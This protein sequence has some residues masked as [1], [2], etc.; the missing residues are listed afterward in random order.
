VTPGVQAE[1]RATLREAGLRGSFLVRDL[2]SGDSLAVDPDVVLPLASLAK[3]PL[4]VTIAERI[5]SGELDPAM[6]IDVP[7][8]HIGTAGPVGIARFRH[9]ARV[10]LED[11]LY[12]AVSVSDNAAADELFALAAPAE[13]MATLDTAGIG[14]IT[15]R[16]DMRPLMETPVERMPAGEAHLA[17]ALAIGAGT[18]DGAHLVTQLDVSRTNTGTAAACADVLDELWNPRA[19]S[20]AAATRVRELMRHNVFRQRLAPDF[21]SDAMTW[22]SKTATLL[23]LRHEAGV[24]EHADGQ[25]IAVVALSESL[26]PAAVQPG[27]EAQISL[28]ARRLHDELRAR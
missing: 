2:D 20:P 12:L 22:S 14:G 6:R 23:N 9:P 10:A 18:R 7:P 24:V 28:A 27:A 11:L 25:R 16:H 21:T 17:H 13:V 19:I 4:A 26:V 1:V 3:V 15:I 5:E 8:G